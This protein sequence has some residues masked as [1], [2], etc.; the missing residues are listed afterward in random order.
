MINECLKSTKL[1]KLTKIKEML[2]SIFLNIIDRIPHFQLNV[3]ITDIVDW[4]SKVVVNRDY[5]IL[6]K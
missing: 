5:S 1:P 2:H 4:L 6:A 3:Q